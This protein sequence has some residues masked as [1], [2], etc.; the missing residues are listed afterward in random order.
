MIS[1][2]DAAKLDRML[3]ALQSDSE[4]QERIGKQEVFD[5]LADTSA[6]PQ[7]GM[8]EE[9]V[10]MVNQVTAENMTHL[11]DISN[12]Q[13]QMRELVQL[14]KRDAEHRTAY[15]NVD[16]DLQTLQARYNLY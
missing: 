11:A 3:S 13:I 9:L 10:Y 15:N 4:F 14:L 8:I 16:S 2:Q 5:V 7:Q 12:L 6:I 1:T